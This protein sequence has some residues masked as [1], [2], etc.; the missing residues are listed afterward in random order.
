MRAS[1]AVACGKRTRKPATSSA[2]RAFVSALAIEASESFSASAAAEASVSVAGG[3][4]GRAPRLRLRRPEHQR[5]PLAGNSGLPRGGRIRHRWRTGWDL[6]YPWLAERGGAACLW[7]L[8]HG[9]TGTREI[10][11][12]EHH[13]PARLLRSRRRGGAGRTCFRA[14]L[15][16]LGRRG[17]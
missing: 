17:R 8:A 4:G 2:S 1:V 13:G 9:N 14:L 5:G 16:R 11:G 15:E 7:P 12:G 6:R 10:G 3:G